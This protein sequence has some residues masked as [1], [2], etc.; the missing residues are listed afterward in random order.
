MTTQ[1]KQSVLQL[2]PLLPN[3]NPK[4]FYVAHTQ[5]FGC[6]EYQGVKM[7]AMRKYVYTSLWQN[8]DWRRKT[9]KRL[10]LNDNEDNISVEDMNY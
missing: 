8:R 6:M 3:L 4:I 5:N 9:N 2:R 1:T 7:Q 10:N